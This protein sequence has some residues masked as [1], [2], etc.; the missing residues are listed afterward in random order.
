[1]GN[2]DRFLTISDLQIPFEA[3]G[4]LA[5][6]T[7]VKRHFKIP[8][9]NC[10]CVGDET[11][12]FFASMYPR[13]PDAPSSP[14]GELEQSR[15]TLRKWYEVFPEMKVAIS[16]HGTRWLRKA[17]AAEIPSQVLR[18]YEELIQAPPGW[19]WQKHW[20][21]PTKKPFL[22]EHGDDWGGQF[23]HK[24]A[25]LHNGMSTVM[26]HHHSI[27]GVE[28][29]KTNGMDVWG[30]VTGCLIDFDAFAFEYAR[31]YK[32]K[33]LLGAGVILDAGKFPLWVPY[34]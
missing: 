23:P 9:S 28:H 26:G 34:S 20:V 19:K 17:I 4:A 6:C 12:Q 25:A 1:M 16:N 22:V 21:I 15:E 8:D 33:P 5:F 30:M 24:T 7:Y 11:D 32:F 27:A 3:S 10:I 14:N 13:N 31:K 29:L 18:A 2:P